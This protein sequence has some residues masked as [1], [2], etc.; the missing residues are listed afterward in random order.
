MDKKYQSFIFGDPDR[1]V[2]LVVY[3]WRSRQKCAVSH[4]RKFMPGCTV[5]VAILATCLIFMRK[6]NNDV[7][8]FYFTHFLSPPFLVSLRVA[9]TV[10]WQ[11]DQQSIKTV[12]E[13]VRLAWLYFNPSYYNECPKG[14][15][16]FSNW[17]LLV[18]L[19]LTYIYIYV[20]SVHAP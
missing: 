10:L 13:R 16:T 1:N 17:L 14:Q 3:L 9:V 8:I 11:A 7:H 19:R 6:K 20:P 4:F 2:Q 12:H 15:L 18:A 5:H